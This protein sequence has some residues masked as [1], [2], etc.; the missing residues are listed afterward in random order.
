MLT[1]FLSVFLFSL[2]LKKNFDT[3]AGL[4]FLLLIAGSSYFILMSIFAINGV[5]GFPFILL[6]LYS[7]Y[8]YLKTKKPFYIFLTFFSLGNIFEAEVAFGLFTIPAFLLAIVLL[9]HVKVFFGRAKNIIYA[10]AGLTIPFLPRIASELKNNFLQLKTAFSFILNPTFHNPKTIVATFIERYNLFKGYYETLM[11]FD[12]KF[13]LAVFLA[14]AVIGL[15]LGYKKLNKDN[16]IFSNFVFSLIGFLFALSLL[17]PDNFW[18][19][20]YEGISF[21]FAVFLSIGISGYLKS[22]NQL[23]KVVPLVVFASL[24]MLNLLKVQKEMAVKKPIPDVGLRGHVKVADYLADLNKDKDFCARVYTPPVIPYTYNYVFSYYMK[25]GKIKNVTT[26]YVDDH[27]FYIM[28]NDSYQFRVDQ[29]RKDHI[30]KG[31]KLVNSRQITD[32]VHIEL[33]EFKPENK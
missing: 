21:Y 25:T 4:I 14:T 10:F 31:A 5:L 13:F 24:L 23:L 12:N 32:N 19:N 8:S 20:Y 15:I 6:F 3:I 33:W 22:K 27:C 30:P 28:E 29:F 26:S 17:Y 11:P 18:N 16:K 9:R 2:F 1:V 7:L